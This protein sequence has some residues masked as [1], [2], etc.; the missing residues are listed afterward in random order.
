M[1][2]F[3]FPYHGDMQWPSREAETR[4]TTPTSSQSAAGARMTTP[5]P[6]GPART[7]ILTVDD[8]PAVSRAVARDLRRATARSYRIV[9]AESGAAGA[10]R[11]ARS[12]KLRGDEVAVL[13]AD[14][15]MPQMNG[16]EFLEQAMDLFPRPAGCCSPPTPTPTPRSRRSTSSTSTTTCSSRGTRRRRSSTRWSTRCSTPGRRH[17][18]PAG[19]R[20]QG[21]R[22]PLVGAVVRGPR[23]PGPQPGPYRWY[24]A[25]EPEGSGCWP[26]P[27]ADGLTLPVVITPDGEALVAPTDAELAARVGLSTTPAEDFYDLVVIGGGPAGLGAAVYGASEGLRTV[28]VERTGDRRA[29]RAELADRELPR[30]PRRRLRR[31]AHRPGPPAG[32]SSSAPSCSPPATSSASRCKGSARG[33]RFA[34]GE[35]HRR[36][37]RHPGHRGVL[38]AARRARPGRAHR[39]RRLLRLGADRGAR[40]APTR[41]STSSAAPTRPARPRCTSP[42][43]RKSVTLL[44]RG[45]VAG[46]RRC[47]TT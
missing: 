40:A 45:A 25:D 29:G 44:V 28:L 6:D 2:T 36:A 3:V 37:H 24:P 47:R 31:P 39:P 7:A 1:G 34:D 30:L 17:G 33:V 43:T 15:R 12:C 27:G 21:R 13:L 10:G 46:A 11:A 26:R 32:Q 4:Q 5:A 41:T 22:A 20:D 38:P 9:R 42:G 19:R 23:L 8:D 35:P 16:I 18:P 14:Y